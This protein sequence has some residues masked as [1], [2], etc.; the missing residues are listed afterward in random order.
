MNLHDTMYGKTLFEY[1]IPKLIK[2]LDRIGEALEENNKLLKA[3]NSNKP[4]TDHNDYIN[5]GE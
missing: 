3:R 1:Q 2:S 4:I 5:K